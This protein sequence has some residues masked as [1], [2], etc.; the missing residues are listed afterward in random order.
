MTI[1]KLLNLFN[2]DK[3]RKYNTIKVDNEMEKLNY[4]YDDDWG[5]K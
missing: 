4:Y 5:H 2:K 3:K 1:S